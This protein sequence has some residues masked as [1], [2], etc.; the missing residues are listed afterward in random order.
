MLTK[1]LSLQQVSNSYRRWPGSTPLRC[2]KAVVNSPLNEKKKIPSIKKL[3]TLA[4][5][6]VTLVLIG[7]EAIAQTRIINLNTG[8]DQWS[9]AKIN[10]G[11][12]DH[13]WRVISDTING[14]PQPPPA[15]GRPADVVSGKL[16]A[17]KDA[18]LAVN[19]PNSRWISITPDQGRLPDPPNKFQYAY[20]FTLPVGFSS[21]VLKMKLSS[22]DHI[23]KVTL[24]R[25]TLFQGSG[26][27]VFGNFL[28]INSSLLTDFNSG[29]I[30][31]VITV[32]V[33]DT[34]GA[35]T[36]LIVDGA[37]SYVDCKRIP[38]KDIPDLTS[39][40]FWESTFA[41]PTHHTFAKDGP[42]LATRRNG[43]LN[44][45]NSDFE[46]LPGLESYDVFYSNWNGTPNPNGWFVTIEADVNIGAPSGGGLNIARVDFN[47]TGQSADS[48]AS[49]VALGNNAMPNDVGKAVDGLTSTDTTM[50]NTIGQTQRLRI[51]VGFPCSAG[52]CTG[53]KLEIKK[54]IVATDNPTAVF[55][56]ALSP[57]GIW[58]PFGVSCPAF[59]GTINSSNLDGLI[60]SN[61][62][63]V[64][65]GNSVTFAIAVENTG[66]SP[67]YEIILADFFPLDEVDRLKCFDADF[68]GLCVTD[69]SGTPIPFTVEPGGH[70][71]VIIKLAPG[72]SLAAGTPFNGTGTNIAIMTFNAKLLD[73]DY[74]KREGCCSN[75]IQLLRYT[76]QPGGPRLVEFDITPAPSDDATFCFKRNC[77]APPSGLLNWW[78][79]DE[80]T[81]TQAQDI[82]GLTNDIGTHSNNP[83]PVTGKV[84]GALSFDGVD[85]FVEIAN[86]R[87][88]N[89]SGACTDWSDPPPDAEPLTIDVWVKTD[90]PAGKLG[91][92]S[93]LLTILDKRVN[94]DDPRGYHLFLFNGRLGF[95]IDGKNFVAPMNSPN[96]AD[97][98][99][100]FVA[101]SLQ[102]CAINGGKLYVDGMPVMATA[103]TD[104]LANTA[105]L[106]IGRSDPVFGANFFQGVLDELEIFKRSL[107][108]DEVRT[109]SEA[110]NGGKCFREACP[111]IT[112]DP[113]SLANQRWELGVNYPPFQLTA[114]GGAGPYTFTAPLFGWGS[115]PTALPAGMFVSAD[116]TVQGQ[117]NQLGGVHNF[118][119]TVEDAKGCLG[120]REYHLDICSPITLSPAAG[121][122][123][124]PV[125]NTSYS[126][127]FEATGGCAQPHKSS[128][129]YSL[130]S[131]TLPT[132]LTLDADNGELWGT[133][134]HAGT[135][136]F[137]VTATD[138]CGCSQSQ[139]YTLTPNV[140][141]RDYALTRGMNEFCI[142]GGGGP[143]NSPRLIDNPNSGLPTNFFT[144]GN[145]S[146]VRYGAIGLCY[147]RILWANDRFA[148]KYTFNAIPVAVLSY[149]DVNSNLGFPIPGSETR[150]NVFGAGLSPI[151]FQLYFR[152]QSRIKPF[153]NTSGGFIYF[154]DSVPRLNG[155]RF[156]FTYDFGG[157]VQV[158]ADSRWAFTFGY[159]YQ[160]I[161]NGG[162]A[163]S[164]PGFDGHVFYFGYSIFKARK[165][166]QGP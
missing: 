142:W 46:S 162:R 122:L 127:V 113:S 97:N 47:G 51:T 69:G 93:G 80:K 58:K 85:D 158:F 50:G 16:W 91:A 116:G 159:K 4:L 57:S 155:A 8:Y 125:I 137:T 165:I 23:T 147:G 133:A 68:S 96:V 59:D 119:V 101:V 76:S 30:V 17:K 22:D 139:T 21:P 33:E 128:F 3:L 153:V 74:L 7:T 120:A 40:T 132:G 124:A 77:V 37:V 45:G 5:A 71:R 106:F 166:A 152:P 163:L 160:R 25:S 15:T 118:I 99:W 49:F 129:K 13:E 134:T 103:G 75:Q 9:K 100:H 73:T 107:S 104:G 44:T 79:F 18:S 19:F 130:T 62:N 115:S 135:Y 149:R 143:F 53:P 138:S 92:N 41:D 72:F 95:Q 87:E 105:K 154:K 29:P 32:D 151:G 36:G 81:G 26:G 164:N 70:G 98:L 156:N 102:R 78:P 66:C 108:D 150:R 131:G 35:I 63:D 114:T 157:G 11:E 60:N 88:V 10:E 109:L 146:S 82:R 112:I 20:Y 6:L 110:R 14:A 65:P 94:P 31:N 148:F 34:G 2:H 126:E 90:L 56:P 61:L 54:G 38:I 144:P 145:T 27:V 43:P 52:N 48:V 121:A 86:G 111:A 39:I 140:R 12:Q 84:G 117:P 67:A 24:N 42:G 136:D 161:S 64:G 55:D 89:F 1:I 123:P 28:P 83:T 141:R